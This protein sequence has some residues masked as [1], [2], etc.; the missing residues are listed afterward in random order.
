MTRTLPNGHLKHELRQLNVHSSEDAIK[1]KTNLTGLRLG[2]SSLGLRLFWPVEM[3]YS[4]RKR[5]NKIVEAQMYKLQRRSRGCLYDVAIEVKYAL[6]LTTPAIVFHYFGY[7][8]NLLLYRWYTDFALCNSIESN[9]SFLSRRLQLV[10]RNITKMK[11]KL[12]PT[13]VIISNLPASMH[14]VIF[15]WFVLHH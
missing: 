13:N 7:K 14:Q 10:R 8:S 3:K 9:I 2:S 1:L 5:L 12:I 4:D 11:C 6:I 15:D